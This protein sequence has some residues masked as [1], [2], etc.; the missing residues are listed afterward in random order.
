MC[1]NLEKDQLKNRYQSRSRNTYFKVRTTLQER[2][3]DTRLALFI[4]RVHKSF[5]CDR[6]QPRQVKY[7]KYDTLKICGG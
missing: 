7:L 2:L 6:R 5:E 1:R 3:G 4:F